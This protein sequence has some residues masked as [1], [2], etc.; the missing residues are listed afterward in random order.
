MVATTTVSDGTGPII[1]KISA[2]DGANTKVVVE[3]NEGLGSTIDATK[4]K[5]QVNGGTARAVG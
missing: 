2:N 3:F 4:F 1:R 5:V